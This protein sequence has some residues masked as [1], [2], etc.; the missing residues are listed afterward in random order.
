MKKASDSDDDSVITE[1]SNDES[2]GEEGEEDQYEDNSPELVLKSS[3]EQHFANMCKI[4][5]NNSCAL[6]LSDLGT[7]KSYIALALAKKYNFPF[8]G[9]ICPLIM[10]PKWERLCKLKG[11]NLKF[12]MAYG[13]LRSKTGKQPKHGLLTRLDIPSE[14]PR[15]KSFTS[16]KV[17][18]TYRDYVK[19]GLLLI[20]DEFQEIKNASAQT[21]A[22]RTLSECILE[23]GPQSRFMMLSGLP[24]DKKEHAI[25]FF[26]MIGYIKHHKLFV[27]NKKCGDL[28]L[29][30]AKDLLDK[31]LE[32][33]KDTTIE[34][35]NRHGY[36]PK[37]IHDMCYEL[38]RD[39]VRP[40]ISSCMTH[41]AINKITVKNEEITICKNIK[42][43][44]YRM[45]EEDTAAYALAV[46]KMAR[47]VRF[48][49]HTQ[50]VDYNDFS[51][52]VIKLTHIDVE[53]AKWPCFVRD[54]R[55]YLK[56]KSTIWKGVLCV[57]YTD[58]IKYLS[59]A[60][61]EYNPMIIKGG[62]S[63]PKRQK[64]IDSFARNDNY[65][66]IIMNIR[67]GCLGI[68]LDDKVGDRPRFMLISP[69]YSIQ[70]VHQASGRVYRSDTKSQP[71]IRLVYGHS[72]L[73]EESILKALRNKTKVA[74]DVVPEQ[75]EAGVK[76]PGHYEDE[77]ED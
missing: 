11:V 12:C 19:A 68:D 57:N 25:N 33:D 6:D 40:N 13:K 60:L 77:Y 21:A 66:L 2:S 4:L 30:G 3:Q 72:E 35:Y 8:V 55:R 47:A 37:T 58:S 50:T 59:E 24:I 9:V 46:R 23:D 44:Y 74:E 43:K 36:N 17:T 54:A 27:F 15:E 48:N 69:T 75:V 62:V 52:G 38:F 65:R 76:F 10:V 1:K 56:M 5:E 49:P 71:E 18:K 61:K 20:I 39:V 16:F 32:F 7:G 26:R 70:L 34:V 53:K 22:C 67:A 31:C 29:Y 45:S 63:V 28:R 73:K 14:N 51:I 64:I 41:P 42:N